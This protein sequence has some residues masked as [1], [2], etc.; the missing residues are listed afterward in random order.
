MRQLRVERGWSDDSQFHVVTCDINRIIARTK[1]DTGLEAHC[2][3][4]FKETCVTYWRL[5]A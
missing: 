5:A 3:K 4:K 1:M 2:L